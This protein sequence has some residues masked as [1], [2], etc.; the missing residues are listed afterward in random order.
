MAAVGSIF[1]Q[2]VVLR[3]GFRPVAAAGMALMGAGALL[4]TQVSFGGSYFGDSFF[5]LF[6]F[7]PSSA[8]GRAS[9]SAARKPQS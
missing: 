6:V 9:A 7:R 5:G 4:N 2:A 1:G 8:S 3:V